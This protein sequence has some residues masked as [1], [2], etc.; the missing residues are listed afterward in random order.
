MFR[1]FIA[2]HFKK[3]TGLFGIFTSNLMVK[4]NQKNYD[5]LMMDLDLQSQ[6]KLLEIGYGPGVG[7]RMIAERCSTCTIHGIDF[8]HL[9]YKRASKYNKRYIDAGRVWL[10]HGDF[11]QAPVAPSDYDKAFCLNVVYFWKELRTPFEKVFDLL[12]KSGSFHIYMADKKTLI[13]KKAPDSV[14][15]KYSIEQI[16]EALKTAGFTV[17][18]H[19][20]EEGYYIKAKK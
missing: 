5:R 16:E 6:D 17:A 2:S 12:K 13:E 1:E 8:S 20:A 10:Q 9:M 19:I 3:P 7:I 14:F 11:L 4:N 15:N 18:E